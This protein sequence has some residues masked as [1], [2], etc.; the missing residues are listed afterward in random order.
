ML[1]H[2]AY[3]VNS[4][5]IAERQGLK[6]DDVNCVPLPF[7]HAYGCLMI[8]ATL[9]SGGTVAAL[10]RF[11]ARDMLEVMESCSA[12]AVSGTPTMFVAALAELSNRNYDLSSLRGGNMAGAFCPPELVREVVERMGVLYGSTEGLVSLMNAPSASLAQRIGTVGNAM[13]GYEAKIVDPQS[14]DGELSE[15]VQGELCIRG[16]SMMRLYY[17]MEETTSKTLDA[18]GWLHSGDLASC[19]S[20]G[21]YRITGRIKDMIIRGGENI[22]PAEIEAF[23]LTHPKVMDSQVVG[24]PCDYYGEDIVAFLRLKREQSAKALEMKRFCRERIA[25]NKVPVMFFFV[26]QFPLTASGKVQKFK[27]KELAIANMAKL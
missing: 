16:S 4:A 9:A 6:P 21:F 12:T 3:L 15:G 24:I 23:L 17:K 10:E 19:D 11:R 26:D 7:F 20:A 1:S 13:P 5:A 27:L 8:L 25:I 14:G 22:Y 2:S 18:E